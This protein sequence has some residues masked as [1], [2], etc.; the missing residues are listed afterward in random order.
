MHKYVGYRVQYGSCYGNTAIEWFCWIYWMNEK[1]Y[2]ES[3]QNYGEFN[4]RTFKASL[5]P[6][7]HEM[8]EQLYTIS[9]NY[10]SSLP[11]SALGLLSVYCFVQYKAIW[12]VFCHRWHNTIAA[13]LRISFLSSSFY[14]LGIELTMQWQPRGSMTSYRKREKISQVISHLKCVVTVQ[15][16][17]WN[18]RNRSVDNA[19]VK[20]SRQRSERTRWACSWH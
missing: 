17:K 3:S 19:V 2:F 8:L 12:P 14:L 11:V 7:N 1:W 20:Q 9:Y 18:E 13:Y 6:I 4:L 10:G 16:L 15:K 5:V